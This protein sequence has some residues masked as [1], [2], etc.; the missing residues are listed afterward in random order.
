MKKHRQT[1]HINPEYFDCDQCNIKIKSMSG[2]RKHKRIIH[3]GMKFLC[4]KVGYCML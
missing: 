2:L 4:D 1:V 3:E